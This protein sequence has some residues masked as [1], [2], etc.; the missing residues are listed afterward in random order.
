[1]SRIEDGRSRRDGEV[2]PGCVD[3]FCAVCKREVIADETDPRCDDCGTPLHPASLPTRI[4]VQGAQSAAQA[5]ET[6]AEP[7]RAEKAQGR[8]AE[9]QAKPLRLRRS[10]Q[11]VAWDRATDDLLAAA[12]REER[13]AEAAYQQAKARYEEAVREARRI[14]NLRELVR[15]ADEPPALPTPR[16]VDRAA[17]EGKRWSR[18]YDAC[19]NCGTTT[20]K[21]LANGR[22]KTCDT[23]WRHTGQERPIHQ[24]RTN[25]GN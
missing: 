5:P 15:V 21:H 23:H 8:P 4:A 2:P 20:V 6:A 3:G 19:R 10:R 13:E 11:A 1:M 16:I 9:A 25:D 12:E 17:S 22:C 14:R 18:K 7:S 24:E